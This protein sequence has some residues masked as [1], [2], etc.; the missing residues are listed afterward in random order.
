MLSDAGL[1]DA[2]G[3]G[4]AA[5]LATYSAFWAFTIWRTL[6]VRLYRNQAFGMGV[7]AASFALF[8]L[9]QFTPV[10]TGVGLG[11]EFIPLHI[12]VFITL[13]YWVDATI[14]AARRSDPL[15]RDTVHW[16]YLRF[17]LWVLLAVTIVISVL[18]QPQ[19]PPLS[20]FLLVA[21]S[22]AVSLPLA[23]RRSG[24]ASMRKLL[25]WFGAFSLLL[26]A[27]V[28]LVGVLGE[29]ENVVLALVTS[30]GIFAA[31]YCLYKSVKSL[32][33]LNKLPHVEMGA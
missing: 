9:D 19:K 27:I 6:S 17:V 28:I 4:V 29:R 7:V 30:V 15:L 13:F 5:L 23:A 32:V 16:S 22:G 18:A 31:T 1:L 10:V 3:H 21:I 25:K 2:A 33:P 14:L 8:Y 12:L 20:A 26:I 11:P 24:V